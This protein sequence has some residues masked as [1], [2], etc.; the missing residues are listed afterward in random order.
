MNK[1]EIVDGHPTVFIMHDICTNPC[2]KSSHVINK[3]L[4]FKNYL[5]AVLEDRVNYYVN[6]LHRN[7]ENVYSIENLWKKDQVIIRYHPIENKEKRFSEAAYNAMLKMIEQLKNYNGKQ[8]PET[9][10]LD[11]FHEYD[12]LTQLIKAVANDDDPNNQVLLPINWYK[13]DVVDW[14]MEIVTK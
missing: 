12:Q 7:K 14:L 6:D 9:K 10:Y 13:S 2:V 3:A 8:L 1:F 5:I 11:F 4:L